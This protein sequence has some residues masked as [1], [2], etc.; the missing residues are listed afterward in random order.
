[1]SNTDIPRQKN[2]IDYIKDLERRVRMLE[3]HQRVIGLVNTQG[4]QFIFYAED[5]VTPIVQIGD[6]STGDRG[7]LINRN[8]GQEAIRVS[9]V[10]SVDPSQM[11][12][13]SD[14]AGNRI[15]Q[16]NWFGGVGIDNPKMAVDFRPTSTTLDVSTM[17]TTFQDMFKARIY[18]QNP[19]FKVTVL[20]FTSGGGVQAE[21][22][23]SDSFFGVKA[24]TLQTHTAGTTPT[25]YSWN[26][27]FAFGNWA[28]ERDFTIQGRVSAG[29]P[30]TVTMRM[31]Y[32]RGD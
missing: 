30:G 32:A 5:G 19:G 4:S 21:I 2:L 24:G 8:N 29:A 6:M 23:L 18:R 12:S 22:Q 25:E 1:M 17:S 14:R 16:E 27:D 15:F 9:K 20:V 11:V 7:V 3:Q 26:T 28:Q 13:V 31:I 10:F